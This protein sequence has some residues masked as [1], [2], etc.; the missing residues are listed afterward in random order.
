VPYDVAGKSTVGVQVKYNGV[1]SAAVTVPVFDSR[2]GVYSYGPNGTG[3]AAITNEDGTINSP[4]N[5]AARGWVVSIYATGAG[6]PDP[7]G[8]DDQITGSNPPVFKTSAYIRLVSDG[9]CDA[10]YFPAEVLYYGGAPQSVPGLIQINAQLPPDVPP[11]D[12]VALYFGLS[13]NSG[14][15]QA[16]T[17]AIQ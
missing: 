13:P 6:L 9:S 3:Q 10:P 8:A 4:F 1:Q 2:L 7:P 17:I 12:A 15:E 16:V 11:G 14:V 5:P